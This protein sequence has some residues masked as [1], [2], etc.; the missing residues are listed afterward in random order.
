MLLVPEVAALFGVSE[1]AVRRWALAGTI[2][3]YRPFGKYLFPSNQPL[4]V[5]R[6]QGKEGITTE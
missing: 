1:A 6:L 2:E 3:W 5:K 4:I